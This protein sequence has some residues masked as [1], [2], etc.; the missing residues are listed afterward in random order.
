MYFLPQLLDFSCPLVVRYDDL[1]GLGGTVGLRKND[2]VSF[3]ALVR[4]PDRNLFMSI[5]EGLECL[6][7]PDRRCDPDLR[8]LLNP[9][10]DPKLDMCE[11]T[12]VLVFPDDD[13][14]DLLIPDL[15]DP[16]V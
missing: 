6:L 7:V 8:V 4:I 11:V 5:R 15:N 12:L 13:V 2:L 3:L 14:L 1:V 10:T 16:T 9:L